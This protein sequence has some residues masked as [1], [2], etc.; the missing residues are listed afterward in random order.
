MGTFSSGVTADHRPR[1]LG[2][3]V[4]WEDSIFCARGGEGGRCDNSWLNLSD[5]RREGSKLLLSDCRALAA[6]HRPQPPENMKPRARFKAPFW[7]AA[8][9][10]A[11]YAAAES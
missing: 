4:A 10:S 11:P 3:G 2:P 9:S 1:A 7:E 6:L 8:P 5:S